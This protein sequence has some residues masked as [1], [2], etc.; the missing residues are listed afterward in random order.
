L[1]RWATIAACVI[2]TIGICITVF[3]RLDIMTSPERN[4]GRSGHNEG[5]TFMSYA[6]PVFPL[7]I[8]NKADD[9]TAIRHTDLDF[10]PYQSKPY[11][12]NRYDGTVVTINRYDSEA[13]ITD[14]YTL[15]NTAD[16]D[17]TVSLFYCFSGSLRSQASIM[18]TI[19]V[20]DKEIEPTIYCGPYS[21]GFEGAWGD[22]EKSSSLNLAELNSWEDYKI[23]LTKDEY[24]ERALDYYPQ[25]NQHVT[26]YEFTDSVA[27]HELGEA[28]TLQIKFDIDSDKTTILTYGFN[29]GQWDEKNNWRAYNYFI[30]KDFNPD[31]GMS[32]YLIV[33]GEDISD[34]TLQ[35]YKDGGCDKGEEIGGVT[36]KVTRYETKLKDILWSITKQ[37]NIIFNKSENNDEIELM[38]EISHEDYYGLVSELLSD[39][40]VLSKNTV[41]RYDEGRLEDILSEVRGMKRLFYLTF[42]VVI[43]A[44]ENI[45][46]NARMIKEASFDFTGAGSDNEGVNGYDL[47]TQL[48][49]DLIFTRQTVSIQDHGLVEIVRQDFGFD[50]EKGIKE[51]IL[52]PSKE[53][54]YIEVRKKE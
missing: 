18:P 30:P 40:G 7:G 19:I 14:D 8:L 29:G 26:V 10:S 24:R 50:L 47:M 28:P 42:D 12:H 44:G 51:V 38:E 5:S 21:G 22:N 23:L 35:G 9:L 45:S 11:Q 37:D 4:I 20:N 39:Y 3:W 46:I 33:L 48:G 49:S 32:R 17:T 15:I 43:P 27:D 52:D 13:I 25:L 16:E 54:Y 2:L 31:Y 53:H 6:G 36:A 41:Q 34:Y 1:K